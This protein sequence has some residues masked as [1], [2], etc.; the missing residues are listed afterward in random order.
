MPLGVLTLWLPKVWE[1]EVVGAGGSHV[2]G[3][4][5]DIEGSGEA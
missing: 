5:Y 2:E 1:E 3:R 4:L